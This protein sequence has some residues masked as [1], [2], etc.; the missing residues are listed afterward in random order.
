VVPVWQAVVARFAPAHMRGR[1]MAAAGMSWTIPAAVGP[2]AA[3]LVIDNLDPEWLWFAC[4]ILGLLAAAG[5]LWLHR[6]A[7]SRLAG[8]ESAT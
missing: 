6:T 7:H 2:L 8:E 5:Y 1:Y 4:F 3:G